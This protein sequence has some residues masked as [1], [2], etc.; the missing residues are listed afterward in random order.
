MQIATRCN[1]DLH[2]FVHHI[3]SE[4]YSI[5]SLGFSH[6]GFN[7]KTLDILPVLLEKGDQEVHG[8]S[9]VLHQLFLSH[10]QVAHSNT[11]AENLLHLEL[12]SSLDII[13]L[14]LH[15]IRVGDHG[16]ELARL[17][18]AR[19]KESGDLFDEGVRAE[20]GIIALG[21]LLHLLL[22]LV[23]LLQIIS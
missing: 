11:E 21:K 20:E 12:D 13:D 6:G 8:K 3:Y 10:V 5:Q 1:M 19:T 2:F 4:Q 17:V 7:M 15:V 18:E 22:V 16:G 9:D 14:L 23:Q